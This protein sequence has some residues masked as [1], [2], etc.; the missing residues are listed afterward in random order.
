MRPDGLREVTLL[1]CVLNLTGLLFIDAGAPT[2]V[3][4]LFIGFMLFGYVV[5]WYF[6]RG[7]NWARW[8]VLLTSVLALLNLFGLPQA[9][10]L[11]AACIVMEAILAGFLLYWLNT[12]SV[13]GYFIT[14]RRNMNVSPDG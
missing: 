9:T 8:L 10:P 5:L 6:W 7:R 2:I 12:A 11:Q 4:P 14:S 13:R 1:M 3:A